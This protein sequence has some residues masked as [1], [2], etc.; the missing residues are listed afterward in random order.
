MLSAAFEISRSS[1]CACCVK[2]SESDNMMFCASCGKA[3]GDD[4]VEL[5]NCTACYLI[6]Y[7]SVKCQKDHRSQHK[8]ECKKRAAELRDEI[9]FKQPESSF[10][11]DCPICCLP[12]P[13]NPSKS[14]LYSCCSKIICN[15]CEHANKIREFEGRL[16]EKCPFCRKAAPG[17]DEEVNEQL[18]KRA[19]A[20]DPVAMCS[21][22]KKRYN[23]GDYQDAFEY[24]TKAAA[25][26]NVMAHYQ[27]SG[28][29]HFGQ[30]VEK[31]EKQELHHSE[32][33]AIG[34]H[35]I[36]RHN[37]AL[38]E[39]KNGQ[40]D[41][42]AKHWIIAAKLGEDT[43]LDS[44]KILYRAGHTSKEDFNAALRGYQAAIEAM[45]SPQ[46]D[47]AETYARQAADCG[48]RGI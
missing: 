3:E 7:C 12:L 43:S 33:A 23:E 37:L 47:E 19:E 1:H 22:G 26:G 15:G 2:M 46:R 38:L 39:V 34:G 36:A 44:V 6:K 17:T 9:L 16:Q 14:S 40:H 45:K 31:N 10:L 18:M 29:Y 20:N 4:G 8:E 25:L 32:Q 30:G 28:L 24:F 11:G 48:R 42:A 5:K 13:I 41:R 27:L 21:M 35:P